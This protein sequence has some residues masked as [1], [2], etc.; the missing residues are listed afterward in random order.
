MQIT[1]EVKLDPKHF[2][3]QV[4]HSLWEPDTKQGTSKERIDECLV[5]L[6]QR[7][8]PTTSAAEPRPNIWH[9]MSVTS[10]ISL[11]IVNRGVQAIFD[12]PEL[13]TSHI[14]ATAALQLL[15]EI[16]NTL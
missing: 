3:I 7:T 13:A 15:F 14:N 6:V 10:A 2:R 1:V 16:F 4:R 12:A 8:H 9:K 5:F 11:E